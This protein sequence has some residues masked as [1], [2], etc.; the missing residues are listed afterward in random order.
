MIL[1]NQIKLQ[2]RYNTNLNNSCRKL[3]V[4]RQTKYNI[5]K[6]WF[7]SGLF[8]SSESHM[9]GLIITFTDKGLHQ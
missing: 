8:Y 6:T 9:G 2:P 1:A 5:T 4:Y 7:T 3:N